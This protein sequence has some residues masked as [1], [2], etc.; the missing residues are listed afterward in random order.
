MPAT[1][2]LHRLVVREA[3]GS[4]DLALGDRDAL[5]EV[6]VRHDLDVVRASGLPTRA[7]PGA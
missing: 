7:A 1:L 3:D 4:V 2:E 6:R 5:A